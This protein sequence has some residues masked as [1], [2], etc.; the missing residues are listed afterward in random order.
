MMDM[1]DVIITA[2]ESPT[3][4]LDALAGRLEQQGLHVGRVFSYGVITGS[5]ST[6]KLSALHDV[7]GVEDIR[8]EQTFRLPQADSVIQ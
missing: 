6:K 8:T 4:G 7:S 1:Q 5:I 2:V 3:G